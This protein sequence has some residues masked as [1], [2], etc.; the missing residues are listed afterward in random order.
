[1]TSTRER[2]PHTR[3]FPSGVSQKVV[4]GC[5]CGGGAGVP[6]EALPLILE[7][8]E[9]PAAQSGSGD[10]LSRGEATSLWLAGPRWDFRWVAERS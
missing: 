8:A 1:M 9:V 3:L 6:S 2:E 4:W 10:T 5:V 7:G